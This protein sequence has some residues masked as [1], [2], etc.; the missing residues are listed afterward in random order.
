MTLQGRNGIRTRIVCGY[1]PCY[2]NK[3]NSKTV[4]QHFILREKDDNDTCPQ[5]RFCQDLVAQMEKWREEGDN[6]IV[7]T[8]ANEKIYKKSIGKPLMKATG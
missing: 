7:C 3:L 4:Y 1:N 6:L 2:N 5:T 8:D